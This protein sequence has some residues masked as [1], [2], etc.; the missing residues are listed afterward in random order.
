MGLTEP[1]GATPWRHVEG[2]CTAS[3]LLLVSGL[4]GTAA[5]WAPVQALLR[6]RFRVAAYDQPGCGHRDPSDGPVS[7]ARLAEDAAD[8]VLSIFGARPVTVVGHST[9][10]AIAQFLAAARPDLVDRLVLSGTWLRA[11]AYMQ[12]LFGYRRALLGRAPELAQGLTALLTE[13]MAGISAASLAPRPLTQGQIASVVARIDALLA[14]DGVPLTGQI[15][16]HCLV[17]GARDDRIV[18]PSRQADLAGALP[19]ATLEMLSEGG[20][21]FPRTRP[22]RFVRCV[23]TWLSAGDRA[24]TR[25]G[26]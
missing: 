13:D 16:A 23:E 26:D 24:A 20:H 11:D 15:R 18:P 3:P 4:G 10:G 19:A 7:I 6:G 1:Q 22:D 12:A 8:T 17:I 14:F 25:H 5:F 2:P 21:F 9:G